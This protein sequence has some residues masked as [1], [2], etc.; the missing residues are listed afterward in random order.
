LGAGVIRY[1]PEGYILPPEK[2]FPGRPLK[3]CGPF[4][5]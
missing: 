5:K 1:V 3:I 4:E 2:K